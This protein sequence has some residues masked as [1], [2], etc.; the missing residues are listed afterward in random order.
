MLLFETLAAIFAASFF[1][2]AR[3]PSERRDPS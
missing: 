1:V 3:R 2:F